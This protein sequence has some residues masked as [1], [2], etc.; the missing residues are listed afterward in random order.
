MAE[1]DHAKCGHNHGKDELL[2]KIKEL[3]LKER[4]KAAALY[5]YTQLKDKLDN[6]LENKIKAL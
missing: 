1:H 5:H 2:K 3:P 6:E 4:V